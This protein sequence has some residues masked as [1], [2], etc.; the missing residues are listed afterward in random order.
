MLPIV[1]NQAT[2]TL[3]PKVLQVKRCQLMSMQ[4]PL[5]GPF[6]YPQIDEQLSGWWSTA[7]TLGTSG[8]MSTA[9]SAGTV[10]ASGTGG[11]PSCFLNEPGNTITFIL[12]PSTADVAALVVSRIPVVTFN[13]ATSPEIAEK[14]HEGL[15]NW[16]AHLAYMK[17]DSDTINLNLAKF[18]GDAFTSEFGPL[19][20][21][22]SD[23]MRKTLSQRT[24]MRAR[25][26]G[27]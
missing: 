21:A 1:A 22:Y 15:M 17:N 24:R 6:F 14:Y 19:P 9:G 13:L 5:P 7:G 27:S 26:F 16:A 25:E 2:Y 23:R 12:A 18:Y 4:Y 20:D 10:G 8:T 11:V 3:S